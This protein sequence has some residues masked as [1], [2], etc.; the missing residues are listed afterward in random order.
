MWILMEKLK[1]QAQEMRQ[2]Q[3]E[4]ALLKKQLSETKGFFKGKERKSIEGKIE[5]VENLE[6]RIHTDMEQSVKQAG[7]P[8]V[9]SFV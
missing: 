8:D 6:K 1:K 4:I 9:Q 5:Q 7:Y 3:K 2:A